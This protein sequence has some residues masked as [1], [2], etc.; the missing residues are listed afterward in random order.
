MKN[1]TNSDEHLT[2]FKVVIHRSKGTVI[3]Y[4]AKRKQNRFEGV[5][6]IVVDVSALKGCIGAGFKEADKQYWPKINPSSHS[7]DSFQV[8]HTYSLTRMCF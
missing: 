4:L 1:F 6:V 8:R 5:Q 3:A 7:P 2:H